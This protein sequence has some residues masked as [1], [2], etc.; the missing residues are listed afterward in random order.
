MIAVSIAGEVGAIADVR[1]A[2]GANAQQAAVAA[3]MLDT[4]QDGLRAAGVASATITSSV[5]S[6]A[7]QAGAMFNNMAVAPVQQHIQAQLQ[8]YGAGGGAVVRV[9]ERQTQGHDLVW[10]L[11]RRHVGLLPLDARRTQDRPFPSPGASVRVGCCQGTRVD[12][13]PRR[14]RDLTFGLELEV[15][16]GGYASTHVAVAEWSRPARS[17]DGQPGH[18]GFAA[19]QPG[20]TMALCRT[21]R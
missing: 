5:R 4:V 15:G 13:P 1:V 11:W 2:F 10:I 14:D 12:R 16:E 21:M 7:D 3:R 17:V 20:D 9:F 8:L 19:Y 6:P 18:L